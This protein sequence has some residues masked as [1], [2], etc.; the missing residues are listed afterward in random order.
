[1]FLFGLSPFPS[2]L[3]EVL[4]VFLLG[5]GAFASLS[6]FGFV[7]D[8]GVFFIYINSYLSKKKKKKLR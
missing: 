1:M 8:F 4:P 2:V 6:C 7:V 3:G 5:W